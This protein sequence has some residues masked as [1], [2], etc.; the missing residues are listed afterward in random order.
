MKPEFQNWGQI[1]ISYTII[2]HF[3]CVHNSFTA[4]SNIASLLKCR[5][6]LYNKTSLKCVIEQRSDIRLRDLTC[7][8]IFVY[9]LSM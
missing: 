2:G 7:I 6:V 4:L 5:G 3:K 1:D 9:H 8:H